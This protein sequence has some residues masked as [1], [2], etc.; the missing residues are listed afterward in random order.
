MRRNIEI[1]NVK[2]GGTHIYQLFT[3]TGSKNRFFSVYYRS[4]INLT[5]FVDRVVEGNIKG[6][7]AKK[8][9]F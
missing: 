8:L 6:M 9:V 7:E 5:L 1:P 4:P 2:T 3:V